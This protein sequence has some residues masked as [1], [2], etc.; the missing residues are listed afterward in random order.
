MSEA[1]RRLTSEDIPATLQL[2]TLAGWN[3]TAGDWQLLMD[4]APDGCLAMEVGGSVV[5]TAT[6]LSYGERLGWIG[7]VLTHPEYR[8]RGYAKH[9]FAR[10][11]DHANTRG[12]KALKLDATDQG[13]PLYESCG[14]KAEQSVERWFRPASEGKASAACAEHA[15]WR[16][17]DAVAFGADRSSLLEVLRRRGKCFANSDAYLLSRPGRI[18]A[19]LGPFIARS[20]D[21][22]R[23]VLV[24]AI[25]DYGTS[26]IFWDLL[27]SNQDAVSLASELGFS[28]QRR[29]TRMFRGEQLRGRDELVYAIAGFELG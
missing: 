3:Q 4:L 2:S 25:S 12:I 27:P 28:T 16:D 5:A 10:L 18:A 1:I 29:L 8:H 26:D 20:R 15:D 14:F 19:Y 17:L 24:Q 21:A 13:Q 7:M 9:L 6:L 22:A 23:A 11:L